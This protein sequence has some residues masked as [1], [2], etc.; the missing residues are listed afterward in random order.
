MDA[1]EQG[2]ESL[3]AAARFGRQLRQPNPSA[4]VENQSW[5]GPDCEIGTLG[6]RAETRKP[7]NITPALKSKNQT[8]KGKN[9]GISQ[10]VK[11]EIFH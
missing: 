3:A 9:E 1:T 4:G 2:N 5:A 7:N 10:D 8:K 11:I 6:W